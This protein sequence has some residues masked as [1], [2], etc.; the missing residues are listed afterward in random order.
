MC[1]AAVAALLQGHQ[2]QESNDTNFLYW[3]MGIYGRTFLLKYKN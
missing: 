3:M 1:Y 2:D